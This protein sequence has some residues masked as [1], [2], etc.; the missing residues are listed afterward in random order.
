MGAGVACGTLAPCVAWGAG[1]SRVS[2]PW[3]SRRRARPGRQGPTSWSWPSKMDGS[4]LIA[5]GVPLR[6][7][8][9]EWS[10]AGDTQFV[11]A[12]AIGESPVSLH[13]EGVAEREALRLLLQPAAGYLAAPRAPGVPGGSL[14]DRVKIRA[15]GREPQA[16]ASGGSPAR[17]AAR[18]E[19]PPAPVREAPA[20]SEADPAR[21]AAAADAAAR[22]GGGTAGGRAARGRGVRA[23]H[24]AARDDRR[25]GGSGSAVE[26]R[27][28]RS[29]TGPWPASA[30]GSRGV[31][32]SRGPWKSR[33]VEAAWGFEADSRP[34]GLVERV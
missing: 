21:A 23:D 11:G 30:A 1:G 32:S 14:Y 6:E 9:D 34:A 20:L 31:S 22:G 4:P 13:L 19:S 7:V 25:A 16:P 24:A 29:G 2:P 26:G 8:L 27:N 33:G 15:V 5:A 28:T 18:R 10:R 3:S 17:G 12:E